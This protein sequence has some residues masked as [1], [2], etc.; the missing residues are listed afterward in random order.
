MAGNRR[1]SKADLKTLKTEYGLVDVKELAV[2]LNRTVDALHWKASQ[3]EIKYDPT[4]VIAINK[5]L[6][7]IETSLKELVDLFHIQA[8]SSSSWSRDELKQLKKLYSEGKSLDELSK[9]FNRP[10]STI[11]SKVSVLGFKRGKKKGEL[12]PKAKQFIKENYLSMTYVD[13]AENLKV[14]KTTVSNYIHKQI[15]L[16][17]F[18]RKTNKK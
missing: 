13:I 14:G 2:K 4:T 3:L 18:K 12:T 10:Q 16:G 5:R 7:A 8:N 1:W 17:N 15:Q 6:D 9:L 11:Y